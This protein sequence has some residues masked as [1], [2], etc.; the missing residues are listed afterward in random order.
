MR[1]KQLLLPN[2]LTTYLEVLLL[3]L[4]YMCLSHRCSP[5]ISTAQSKGWHSLSDTL[6]GI[7]PCPFFIISPKHTR[8]VAET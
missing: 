7:V 2:Y 3:L 5:C 8:S 6:V 4:L 1:G